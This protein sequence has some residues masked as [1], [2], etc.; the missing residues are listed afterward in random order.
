MQDVSASEIE[1]LYALKLKGAHLILL[2]NCHA[3]F[4]IQV[5]GLT[6]SDFTAFQPLS[7]C[8]AKLEEF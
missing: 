2:F 3:F 4:Y 6:Y 8:L 1:N 5:Q 7:S